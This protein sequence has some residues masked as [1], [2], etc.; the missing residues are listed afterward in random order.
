MARHLATSAAPLVTLLLS[1]PLLGGLAVACGGDNPLERGDLHAGCKVERGDDLI[2][3]AECLAG[4]L[5]Y[6]FTRELIPDSRQRVAYNRI[7]NGLL[8]GGYFSRG[9]SGEYTFEQSTIAVELPDEADRNAFL[10]VVYQIKDS[11][12]WADGGSFGA[13]EILA[14]DFFQP[15]GI[16]LLNRAV[17]ENA[18]SCNTRR[19]GDLQL[20]D[21]ILHPTPG[22]KETFETL[23]RCPV[24]E[25][26][27]RLHL[28]AS[29]GLA[30]LGDIETGQAVLSSLSEFAKHNPA[31]QSTIEEVRAG[32]LALPSEESSLRRLL[33]TWFELPV[34]PT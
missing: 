29:V 3:L 31:L 14:V 1:W 12:V 17:H 26:T 13:Y 2:V 32:L 7:L 27:V 10:G 8:R 28:L 23:T 20:V 11:R 34:S 30:R 19:L 16:R 5:S 22:V 6:Y 4:E 24:D 18:S 21:L 25:Q 15:E 33:A 9:A